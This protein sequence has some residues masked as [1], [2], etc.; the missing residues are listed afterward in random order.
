MKDARQERFFNKWHRQ[1]IHY[2]IFFIIFIFMHSLCFHQCS[3]WMQIFSS[4][5]HRG[6]HVEKV[7]FSTRDYCIIPQ[8]DTTRTRR[9]SLRKRKYK[10]LLK[11]SK[12][13][14]HMSLHN[15]FELNTISVLLMILYAFFCEFLFFATAHKMLSPCSGCTYFEL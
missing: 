2:Y 10:N 13:W 5:S 9:L 7:K 4:F 14:L 3:E 11:S 8:R 1:N 6:G 12:L 15:F